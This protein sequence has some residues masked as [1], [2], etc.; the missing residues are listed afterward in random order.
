MTIEIAPSVLSAD[1]GR[2]REQVQEV[3]AVGARVIH[4]DVMDGHFVPPLSMGPPV[5]R[6]LRGLGLHLEVH[7][8]VERPERQVASFA[9]AGADTIIVH[10]E[11]TPNVHYALGA[12][13][14]AG[15][16]AGLAVNPATPLG[17]FAEVEVDVALCMSVNPGWGGQAFIPASLDR[18]ARLRAII[19]Q[20]PVL[21]VDGGVDGRTAGPC[22]EAGATR[23]VAGNAV[24]GAD[25]PAAAYGAIAAAAEAARAARS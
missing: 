4:I 5:C 10:A 12:V 3:Q 25:D 14:D 20:D 11:A 15:C 1:F 2:L 7:L 13:R 18:I 23:L 6:A 17:I 19:G 24:F 16:L 9:E 21:E 8:M 22:V